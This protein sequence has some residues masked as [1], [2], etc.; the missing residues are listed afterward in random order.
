MEIQEPVQRQAEALGK[1]LAKAG[2]PCKS[3]CQFFSCAV[4]LLGVWTEAQACLPAFVAVVQAR[5]AMP[6]V[7]ASRENL[8]LPQPQ[9]TQPWSRPYRN[10]LRA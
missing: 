7:P 8:A 1:L 3:E 9:R 2:T 5:A 10:R 6:G 4:L